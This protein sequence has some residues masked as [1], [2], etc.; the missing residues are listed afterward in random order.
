M[1]ALAASACDSS[2]SSK[3]AS[4]TAP[5]KAGS[6]TAT[7]GKGATDK[8][9]TTRVTSADKNLTIET[10]SARAAFVSG[11]DV[12]VTLSGPAAG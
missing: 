8:G 11:G 7:D 9:A 3:T 4:S 10:T 6:A 12:L 1:L 2:G 5:P